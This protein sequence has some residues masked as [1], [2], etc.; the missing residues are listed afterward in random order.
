MRTG[1]LL[2]KVASAPPFVTVLSYADPVY[3]VKN[4]FCKM[5]T[6]QIRL[7]VMDGVNCFLYRLKGPTLDF[8]NCALQVRLAV[9]DEVLSPLPEIPSELSPAQKRFKRKDGAQVAREQAKA[10]VLAKSECD[11]GS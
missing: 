4:T 1:G 11:I 5:G 10:P 6:L 3:G 8:M 2:V 9:P 7:I